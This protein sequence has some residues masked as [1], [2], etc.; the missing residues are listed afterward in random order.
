[1]TSPGKILIVRIVT[2]FLGS[3]SYHAEYCVCPLMESSSVPHW[4]SD[5]S[6][7]PP[8]PIHV[9]ENV[10]LADGETAETLHDAVMPVTVG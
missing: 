3:S 5:V 10:S 6:N 2:E 1:M 8:T 9:A 4:I 7:W